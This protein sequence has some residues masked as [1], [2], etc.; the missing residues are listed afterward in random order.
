MN[1]GDVESTCL[2]VHFFSSKQ[3]S[4]FVLRTNVFLSLSSPGYGFLINASVVNTD[5]RAEDII[6]YGESDH[7]KTRFCHH[8]G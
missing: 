5:E 7:T 3:R 8:K 4:R 1:I 6:C 2:I